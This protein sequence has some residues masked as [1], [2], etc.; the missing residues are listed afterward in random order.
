VLDYAITANTVQQ[1]LT[2]CVIPSDGCLKHLL[3]VMWH[4]TILVTIQ[5]LVAVCTIYI[6]QMKWTGWIHIVNLHHKSYRPNLMEFCSSY[7]LQ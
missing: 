5:S 4:F 7:K 2:A 3:A 1:H 6:H